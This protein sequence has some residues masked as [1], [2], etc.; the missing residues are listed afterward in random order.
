M[1]M[2][3]EVATPRHRVLVVDDDAAHRRTVE[4]ALLGECAVIAASG[5]EEA[6]AL[7]E[8]GEVSL[9]LTDQRMP[10]MTGVE[11]L[12]RAA[13]RHPRV[14]RLLFTAYAEVETLGEAINAGH[15]FAFL[16]KPWQ[17]AELRLAVRRGLDWREAQS[18]REDLVHRLR[19]ACAAAEREAEGKTRLLA[20]LAHELGTPA[21]IALNAS[22]LLGE[23][24]LPATVRRWV[25]PLQRAAQWMARGVA[26]VH[27]AGD[28]ARQPLRLRPGAVDVRACVEEVA[29]A[30]RAAASSRSLR[31]ACVFEASEIPVLRADPRWLREVLWNLLSN[32]VRNTADGGWI[33]IRVRAAGERVEIAVRD[34]GVGIA[35]DR[36]EEIFEPFANVGDVHLHGSGWLAFGARGLGL[37][38]ALTRR[39]ATA[40]GGSVS[41][42]ST[43]GAGSC[44]R[45]ELPLRMAGV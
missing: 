37:G 10:G 29:A 44:F 6:L 28:G 25:E 30:M 43:V 5:G 41:V 33:E 16:S 40:H 4:R 34:G 35:A 11:L 31:L 27:R 21:H 42:Q 14:V 32:A 18:E 26:Q 1:A 19:A 15:V 20:L 22:A 2:P 24:E 38:L 39:V 9:L 36:W 12:A 17:P 7:L 23:M 8:G 13:A 3:G 45:L